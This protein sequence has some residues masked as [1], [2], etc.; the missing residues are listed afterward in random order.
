MVAFLSTELV[1]KKFS[2]VNLNLKLIF[3]SVFSQTFSLQIY[4]N[5]FI[6]APVMNR[7]ISGTRPP[8]DSPNPPKRLKPDAKGLSKKNIDV[9]KAVA[10]RSNASNNQN[11]K[12]VNPPAAGNNIF[13][14][15]SDHDDMDEI[16]VQA[17]SKSIKPSPI[18]IKS[19]N[20]GYIQETIRRTIPNGKFSI[21]I[22]S[23]GLKLEVTSLDDFDKI[24]SALSNEGLEYFFYHTS[25]TKPKRIVLKG[26]PSLPITDVENLLNDCN[27]KPDSIKPLPT[28]VTERC[29]Y[30]LYYKPASVKLHELKQIKC[31]GFLKVSWDHFHSR[32]P[33]QVVQCRNCQLFGHNSI[34]CSMKP[35]CLVCAKEHQTDACPSRIPR[36]QLKLR[37]QNGP[38]D[39][40]FIKCANCA[41]AGLKSDHTANWSGCP[42]RIE[43]QEIQKRL[44]LKN[45]T[46]KKP[47]TFTFSS[48]F[49]KCD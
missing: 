21:K 42:K 45:P 38:I 32:R 44:T 43:Y 25:A 48:A 6:I 13:N 12:K 30:V 23:I 16:L 35:K 9:I 34:N 14:I 36:D 15:L 17:P 3:Q 24:K 18:I 40:S 11:N 46:N 39:E 1:E 22:L 27:V 37:K 10:G 31:L 4:L 26:L 49:K 20:V 41:A 29:N 33:N 5:P 7:N 28:R 47:H 8:D 19:R 2:L